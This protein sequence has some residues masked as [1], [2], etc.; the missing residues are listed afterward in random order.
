MNTH[1]NRVAMLCCVAVLS[2]GCH[3]DVAEAGPEPKSIK[4]HVV[5][6]Q[7]VPIEVISSGAIEAIDKADIAFQV[8]GR[9]ITVEVED[10]TLVQKGQLLARL[11]PADYQKSLA[12]AEAQ[13]Q[14]VKARHA[15]LTR[16][17]AAGSLTDADFDKIDAALK[18]A[19]SATELARR[20][21]GYTELCAPF[22]GRIVKRGI[23]A[24]LVASKNRHRNP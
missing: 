1:F 19:E 5:R 17:H 22:D 14:E 12:I 10:G 16:M 24:G 8:P 6:A 11:D 23:A 15:R 4:A 2:G 3:R 13:L 7:E 9:V 20:Q 21:V 18:Q